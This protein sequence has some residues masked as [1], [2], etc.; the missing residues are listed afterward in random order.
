M[1][2]TFTFTPPATFSGNGFGGAGGSSMFGGGAKGSFSLNAGN[3]GGKYGGGGSGGSYNGQQGGV[4]SGRGGG[5]G[6]AGLV[7]VWE[8]F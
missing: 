8:I 3:V 4:P 7:R 2:Q 5:A 1:T 6:F